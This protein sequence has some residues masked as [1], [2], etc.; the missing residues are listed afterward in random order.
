MTRIARLASA[1]LH[2]PMALAVW[3]G[4]DGQ[5]VRGAVGL[6]AADVARLGAWFSAAR[7]QLLTA[8]APLKL[9]EVRARPPTLLAGELRDG[10]L[11]P[12]LDGLVLRGV[13]G[14]FADGVLAWDGMCAALDDLAALAQA[15]LPQAQ[16]DWLPQEDWYAQESEARFREMADQAPVLMW[17]AAP[18]GRCTFFNRAWLAFTGRTLEQELGDGWF[19]TVHPRDRILNKRVFLRAASA[20]APFQ[21]EYRVRRADGQYRWIYDAGLPVF[22]PN[23]ELRCYIGAAIDITE[24]KQVEE[25]IARSE[26][27]Y[28]SIFQFMPISIWEEDWSGVL[29]MLRDLRRMGV[30]DYAQYV[31][32]HPEGVMQALQAVRILDVND[33]TVA[34]FKARDK[35][36]LLGS[37][38]IVFS[39]PELLPGFVQELVAL[40]S[41]QPV[42]ETEMQLRTL[43]GEPLHVLLRMSFPPLDGDSG[44]VLVGLIDITERKRIEARQAHETRLLEVL[45]TGDALAPMLEQVV[46]TLE[47]SLPPLRAAVLLLERDGQRWQQVVAPALPAAYQ[48]FMAQVDGRALLAACA[49]AQQATS[50]LVSDIESDPWWE[51]L[52]AAARQAGLRT[53]WLVPIGS[54]PDATSAVMLLYHPEQCQPRA[55]ERAWLARLARMVSLAIDRV[56]RTAALRASEEFLRRMIESSTDCIK[57]LDL[58]GRLLAISSGGQRL[59]EIDDLQACLQSEWVS[60]WQ[61]PLQAT[62]RAAIA[63]ARAGGVGRFSGFCPT[64]K[65]TPKWWDVVVTPMLGADGQPQQLLAVSRD[66]SERVQAEQRLQ[67][68]QT[69]TAELSRAVTPKQ[70]ARVTVRQG[71]AATNGYAG[72]VLALQGQALQILYA[73]GYER[74][75]IKRWQHVPLDAPLPVVAVARSGTPLWLETPE[76]IGEQFPLF[77]SLNASRSRALAVLPLSSERGLL[78]VLSIN[79]AA[80]RRF[81]TPDREL[82]LALARQGAQALERAQ[83]YEAERQA[84]RQA[85]RAAAVARLHATQLSGLARAALRINAALSIDQILETTTSEARALIGAHQA[86]S[87]FTINQN[88]AQAINTVSL[89]DKYAAWRDYDAPPDGSGIYAEVCRTNRPMRLTQAELEAHPLWRAFGKEAGRYPPMRGWL[90]APLVGRDGRNIGLLQLSDKEDGGDF[91]AEDEAI[92]VQ[93][94]QMA[95]VAVEN[96]RLYRE[97]QEAILARDEFL[98]VASHELKTPLTALELQTQSL[99]R[100]LARQADAVPRERLTSKLQ[101]IDQQAQRLT[102]LSNDLLDVARIRLGRIELRFESVDL[103]AL[104]QEVLARFEE[105]AQLTGSAITLHA[106]SALPLVTDRG[107]VEQILTNLLSNALKYGAGR[108]IEVVLSATAT[109]VELQVRDHGIGIA[110]EH[111]ERIFVRFERVV[112]ARHYSGLGLGLYITRQLVEALGGQIR[113]SSAVNIGSTF[114]VSLPRGIQGD[115]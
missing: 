34:L 44:T 79:F 42:F 112:S 59:M 100:L 20:R 4:V 50:L 97:A 17:M 2:A 106:P 41:G 108:P 69:V 29:E 96:A 48:Q 70:V 89:S 93:L 12:L 51:P 45:S 68:L 62:V 78:G 87:S 85:Q 26:E 73:Q 11:M 55:D 10:V 72:V 91:T 16:A 19:D 61:G 5:T 86:V 109:Q 28:R 56:Q 65:G 53:C 80:P 23:G 77:A 33:A 31:A 104:A 8:R 9:A 22:A 76:Q 14:V 74:H 64:M 3:Y 107:R 47:A 83:L 98:S 57:V 7:P 60:F 63:T 25:R 30:R 1:M 105:Q 67:R 39:S 75:T 81:E 13:I 71:L 15:A 27:R 36:Q 66:I 102:Q 111:L 40:S 84:R 99:L 6:P 49:A 37:L 95:A 103:V 35:Q 88:W 58:E 94:A 21:M 24:R 115:A 113:V 90:A 52:R 92:L 18:D 46:L 82:L 101:L 114:T 43:T 38:Q 110:P 54:A 32:E